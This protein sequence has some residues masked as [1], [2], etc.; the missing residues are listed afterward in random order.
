M[1]QIALG[2]AYLAAKGIV[3]RDLAARNCMVAPPSPDTDI[4][5]VCQRY[6]NMCV[7]ARI[8]TRVC[9]CSLCLRCL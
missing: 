4:L 1:V 9:L 7:R 5:G 3:H 2:M 8:F 6:V